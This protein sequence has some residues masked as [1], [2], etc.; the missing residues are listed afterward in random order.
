MS[1]T[2]LNTVKGLL[3]FCG[4]VQHQASTRLFQVYLESLSPQMTAAVVKTSTTALFR[5][6]VVKAA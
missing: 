3:Y 1:E 4:G 2:Q 6:P 5:Y